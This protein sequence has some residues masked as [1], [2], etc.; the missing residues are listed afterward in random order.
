MATAA[1]RRNLPGLTGLRGVA[2]AW[3][4]VFHLFE[5]Q[6]GRVVDAGWLGVDIFFFLSGFVLSYVYAE[7]LDGWGWRDHLRFIKVRLARIYPL[8][9]VT[10][11]VLA[12]MVLTLPGFAARYP[13]AE[14]RWSPG[15]FAASLL[16]VQNWGYFWPDAWNGPAWSL[17]A[18]WFAYL[19]F[20]MFLWLT[21]WPRSGGP[22]LAG[23]AVAFAVLL[24]MLGLGGVLE[25]GVTSTLGMVRMACEFAIGC[26]LYRAWR[27]GLPEILLRDRG[28]SDA[29]A[30]LLILAGCLIGP[31]NLF[32]LPGCALLVLRAGAGHSATARLLTLVPLVFL[33]EISYSLYLTHWPLIQLFNWVTDGGSTLVTGNE[34]SAKL[35]LLLAAL[36]LSVLCYH[37]I[38]RPARAFGRRLA[39]G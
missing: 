18:E 15:A 1:S 6:L 9:L 21:Q 24:T 36:L 27:I 17:S 31:I 13:S 26:G 25:K 34:T 39:L 32:A 22:L 8:H 14:L 19:A 20:P 5:H 37:A 11:A 30:V 2:A 10:L 12:V 3:V 29:A 23:L 7:S 4:V 38:E 35:L 33:G 16:L 28:A